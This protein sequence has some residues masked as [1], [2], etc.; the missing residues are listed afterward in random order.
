MRLNITPRR[1]TPFAQQGALVPTSFLPGFL[2]CFKNC[3]AEHKVAS[4]IPTAVTVFQMGEKSKDVRVSRYRR[5]LVKIYGRSKL[6]RHPPL[7]RAS[8]PKCS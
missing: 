5:T 2:S 8:Y 1:P 7:R 4:S 6:I 3:A